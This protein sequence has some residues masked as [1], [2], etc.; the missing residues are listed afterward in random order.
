M[1]RTLYVYGLPHSRDSLLRS[2]DWAT[3]RE[4]LRAA[5][6]PATYSRILRGFRIRTDRLGDFLAGAELAGWHI[7]M[8][9][10]LPT[11]AGDRR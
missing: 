11:E 4:D 3:L 5:L 10:P 7:E 6:I 2:P 9:G 1:R 8:R